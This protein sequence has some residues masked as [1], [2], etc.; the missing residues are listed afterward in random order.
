MLLFYW[1]V[2]YINRYTNRNYKIFNTNET[3]LLRLFNNTLVPPKKSRKS[4]QA[5]CC[6]SFIYLTT[7]P[8]TRQGASPISDLR[9]FS[10]FLM[11]VDGYEAHTGLVPTE[12]Q[13]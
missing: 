4:K 1:F 2:W 5:D 6:E 11:K 3:R 9:R 13:H 10:H 8:S 12:V 7:R